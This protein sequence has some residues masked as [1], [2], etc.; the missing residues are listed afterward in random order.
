MEGFR[1]VR[2]QIIAL[3]YLYHLQMFGE[4]FCDANLI[5]QPQTTSSQDS[6]I[7][8]YNPKGAKIGF[9]THTPSLDAHSAFLMQKSSQ[10][11]QDIM[12]KVFALNQGQCGFFSL[13]KTLET[14]PNPT[15]YFKYKEILLAQILQCDARVFV[16]FGLE[17]VAQIL[18]P[19]QN[20]QLGSMLKFREK[21]LIITHSLRAL[22]RLESLKKQT[23]QHLLR[24]KE[25]I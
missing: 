16:I 15:E 18:F 11:L 23:M 7:L 3:N 9:I 10:M 22:L 13:F 25:L 2:N 4:E 24:A 21:T 1:A 19:K 20:L 17:E 8:G 6:Q 5:P 12:H 14:L